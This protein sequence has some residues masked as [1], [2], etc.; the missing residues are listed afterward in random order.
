M[1]KDEK[2]DGRRRIQALAGRRGRQGARFGDE[3][4][5]AATGEDLGSRLLCGSLDLPRS[6]RSVSAARRRTEENKNFK[7]KIRGNP[8]P[9]PGELG[10]VLTT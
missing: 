9:L 2:D 10:R 1:H 6:D 3:R 5:P 4:V 8:A 7:G